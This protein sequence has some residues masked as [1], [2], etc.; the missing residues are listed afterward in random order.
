MGSWGAPGPGVP[1]VQNRVKKDRK[2]D[3]FSTCLPLFDSILHFSGP[4]RG[5]G[6]PLS[7]FLSTLGPKGSNDSCNRS[8]RSQRANSKFSQVLQ[9]LSDC[10]LSSSE[11]SFLVTPACSSRPMRPAD[12]HNHV[13]LHREP[14]PQVK[15]LM[16]LPVA[17]VE[18]PNSVKFP[19]TMSSFS[20]G[21]C[22]IIVIM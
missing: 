19:V 7:D 11:A 8:R 10:L 14:P 15:L 3:Y 1:K 6:N 22:C 20:Q 9:M 4:P 13:Y 17:S 2:S 16:S 12:A 5:P 21:G 18:S